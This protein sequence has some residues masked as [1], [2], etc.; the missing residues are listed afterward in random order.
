MISFTTSVLSSDIPVSFI[1]ADM[2]RTQDLDKYN[3]GKLS[4]SDTEN[5]DHEDLKRVKE[6]IPAREIQHFPM[7]GES[8][9]L[10]SEKIPKF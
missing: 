3:L 9:L 5:D 7:E 1:R 8:C 6:H 2:D 10:K 4:S